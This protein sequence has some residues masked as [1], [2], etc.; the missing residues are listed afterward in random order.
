ML[1]AKIEAELFRNLQEEFQVFAQLFTGKIAEL[2]NQLRESEF[3]RTE[4][5][6]LFRLRHFQKQDELNDFRNELVTRHKERLFND[7][8]HFKQEHAAAV[9]GLDKRFAELVLQN[10]WVHT[11]LRAAGQLRTRLEHSSDA[12][13][14][15]AERPGRMNE[16]L[17]RKSL[18]LE[19]ELSTEEQQLALR[20][21]E[22]ELLH[23]EHRRDT[24]ARG[25]DSQPLGYQN[26]DTVGHPGES[27]RVD[28]LRRTAGPLSTT[29]DS[30]VPVRGL[31][32]STTTGSNG[33]QLSQRTAGL[34]GKCRLLELENSV[35]LARN[36]AAENEKDK[37]VEE[38]GR[39]MV[40]MHEDFRQRKSRTRAVQSSRHLDDDDSLA[41]R[42][43]QQGL[44]IAILTGQLEQ[45]RAVSAAE[46]KALL[47]G[48]WQQHAEQLAQLDRQRGSRQ[49]SRP[50]EK[51]IIMGSEEFED[52]EIRTSIDG[53]ARK[54]LRNVRSQSPSRFK[55]QPNEAEFQLLTLGSVGEIES[56]RLNNNSE[57]SEVDFS[58]KKLGGR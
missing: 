19:Q 2:K 24:V 6:R 49:L 9:D 54:C 1:S 50:S 33:E 23:L 34:R 56:V 48:L 8:K 11:E 5:E 26:A 28:H 15:E 4:V 18:A 17:L 47:A 42:L 32:R 16:S 57:F 58:K 10:D 27:V 37:K 13:N 38:F 45:L 14:A 22:E 44:H 30:Q 39:V 36:S 46:S 25:L 3:Q 53:S 31:P 21:L 7:L 52:F 41:A 12:G 20:A 29:N 51:N 43:R 40:R 55:S 35:L